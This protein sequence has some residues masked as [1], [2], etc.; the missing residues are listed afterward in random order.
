MQSKWTPVYSPLDKNFRREQEI[1]NTET[2]RTLYPSLRKSWAC[3]PKA[4]CRFNV[5]E[6]QRDFTHSNN[7]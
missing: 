5:A 3:N 7:E 6:I 4:T 2:A 1:M